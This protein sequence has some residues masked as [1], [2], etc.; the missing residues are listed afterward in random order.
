VN[1]TSVSV[2]PVVS[3]PT[4]RFSIE[5]ALLGG[6]DLDPATGTISGTPT[7]SAEATYLVTAT[8]GGATATAELAITALPG[9]VV[10]SIDDVPDD[11][12]GVDAVCAVAST[13]NLC[14]LRAA[15]QTVNQRTGKQLVLLDAQTY[16]LG[17]ALDPIV[18]D[19]EIVGIDAA[20]TTIRAA[21][22]HPR[23]PRSRSP[24]RTCSPCAI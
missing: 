5:P 17:A 15:I 12:A 20:V 9:Y 4:A 24:C 23:M 13:G 10:T 8:A 14:T 1:A 18:N 3:D 21:T 22:V 11:D 7:E 16:A 19:V 2:V 6:L